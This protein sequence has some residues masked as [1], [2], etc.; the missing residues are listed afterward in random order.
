M[1]IK[2]FTFAS[3]LFFIITYG[4]ILGFVTDEHIAITA[5]GINLPSLQIA[6]WVLIPLILYYFA[7][8]AHMMYHSLLGSLKLR[9]Y[10]KDFEKLSVAMSDA[11]LSK[12]NRK[13]SYKTA[14]Y[15]FFG[16]IFDH[17]MIA[18]NSDLV[19]TG[20]EQVDNALAILNDIKSG[21]VVD[22]KKQNLDKSNP[23]AV[24]NE[25]NR[26]HNG[27]ISAEDILSH[28]DK[29]TLGLTKKA[30]EKFVEESAFFAIEKYG[31]FINKNSLFTVLRRINAKEKSIEVA[32]EALIVLIE[33]VD[34]TKSDYI[35]ISTVLSE[36]MLP[37]QRIKLF[38]L[39]SEKENV[40]NEVAMDAYLYTLFDLEMLSPA[41]EI[42]E[43]SQPDEYMNFKAYRALKGSNQNFDIH[44]FIS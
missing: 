20:N 2:R 23:F 14:R 42:L 35:E 18:P 24:A 7:A 25:M 33:L 12:E 26:F 34:L 8:I 41:D 30:Y 27:D 11:I 39:L 44:L 19:K 3:I 38:E 21:K 6:V 36:N 1:H 9:R 17:S 5:F 13:N 29:Y 15:E 22:L 28:A 10:E 32:N 40:I 31:K 37:D 4:Y 43:N 16:N